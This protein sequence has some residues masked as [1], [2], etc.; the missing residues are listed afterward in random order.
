MARLKVEYKETIAPKLRESGSYKNPMQVPNVQKIVLNMGVKTSMDK[1]SLKAIAE[2]MTRITGQ[3]AVVTKARKSIANFKLREEMPIGVKV[4]LRGDRMYEFLDRLINVALP[5][6]RDFRG[7]SA[8]SF[9]GHGNYSFG[10]SEQSMFPEID[11]DR[12]KVTQGYGYNNSDNSKNERRSQRA[13]SSFWD[14]VCN[15]VGGYS[16][17]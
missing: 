15:C 5:R 10:L 1:D 11:P 7:I 16:V 2:D 12:M 6:I 3:R 8:K 17:G 13:A 4:T 14:A 9:D